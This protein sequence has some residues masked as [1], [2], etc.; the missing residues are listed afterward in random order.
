MPE[1]VSN[2]R[3][4][5]GIP[6]PPNFSPAGYKRIPLECCWESLHFQTSS[7]PPARL[8]AV[9]CFPALS[10][11]KPIVLP[12]KFG[13]MIPY[14][15]HSEQWVFVKNMASDTFGGS[16]TSAR[17]GCSDVSQEGICV[18]LWVQ[19]LCNFYFTILLL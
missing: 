4:T 15:F 5:S 9:L 12:S 14:A 19:W 18:P 10:P 2:W 8:R 6:A 13:K 11:S 7:P 1:I 3:S 17:N 16:P